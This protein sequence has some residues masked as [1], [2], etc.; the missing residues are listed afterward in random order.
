MYEKERRT[1]AL[2]N[3]AMIITIFI[4]CMGLFGLAL[5]TA[6]KRT[7]EIG[8]RKVLGAS[9][10]Q[11]WLLLSKDFMLLVIISCIIA[12]P[13]AYYF[14]QGWLQKYDYRISIGPGVF[15]AAALVA[16]MLT[17]FTISFQAIRAALTNPVKSLKAE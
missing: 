9:V 12:S 1:A 17:L 5:F 8:I 13:V 4:S 11:L 6:E 14:L 16:M 15:V 7:K 10:P 3:V 2:V